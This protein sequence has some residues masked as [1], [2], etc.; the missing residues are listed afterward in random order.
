MI[1][2]DNIKTIGLTAL[3]L[4]LGVLGMYALIELAVGILYIIFV[5]TIEAGVIALCGL[6]L[7]FLYPSRK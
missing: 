7:L 5:H 2:L 4:T 1:T 3:V 6:T